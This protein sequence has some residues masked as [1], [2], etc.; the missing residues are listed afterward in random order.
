VLNTLFL[1]LASIGRMPPVMAA[2]LHNANTVGILGYAA[3]AGLGKPD[4]QTLEVD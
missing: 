1:L 4:G 2:V 3:L